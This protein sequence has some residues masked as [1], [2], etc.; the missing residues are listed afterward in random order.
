MSITN[1]ACRAKLYFLAFTTFL[2]SSQI[3]LLVRTCLY[4]VM[5]RNAIIRSAKLIMNECIQ[6]GFVTLTEIPPS[7]IKGLKRMT[8]Y[9]QQRLMKCYESEPYLKRKEC[10]QLAQSLNTSEDKIRYWFTERRRKQRKMG[11]YRGGE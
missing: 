7:L 1:F 3:S 10:H 8:P 4:V 2:L 11:I 6:F 9:Q 5:N